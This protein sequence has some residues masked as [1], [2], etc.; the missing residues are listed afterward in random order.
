MAIV[1][2]GG[3]SILLAALALSGGCSTLKT[4]GDMHAPDSGTTSSPSSADAPVTLGVIRDDPLDSESLAGSA[5]AEKTAAALGGNVVHFAYDSDLL[6]DAGMAL[7]KK[8]AGF[9]TAHPRVAVRL[10]GHTDEHGT[11][12]YNMALGERRARAV[13]VFL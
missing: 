12:E 1:R 6:S 5:T 8:H 7:L 4:R 2:I 13:A 11:Q 10:E 9:M 3:L